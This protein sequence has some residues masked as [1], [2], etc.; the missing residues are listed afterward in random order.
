MRKIFEQQLSFD[1]IPIAEVKLPEGSRDELPPV[2]KALQYIYTQPSINTKIFNLLEEKVFS[3]NNKTGR[4]GMSLW[5]ILVLG[6]VRLCLDIDYDRLLMHAN[7]DRLTRSIL[8]VDAKFSN[9]KEYSLQS[10]KDNIHKIDDSTLE[11]INQIVVEAGYALNK[12]ET[13]AENDLA[14]KIDTYAMETN[15]HFPTDISLLWDSLR[16]SF[17]MIYKLLDDYTV[18]GWR[19]ISWWEKQAKNHFTDSSRKCFN[20]GYNTEKKQESVIDYLAIAKEI[21]IKVEDTLSVLSSDFLASRDLKGFDI[22][23]ELEYYKVFLDKQIDL[24]E[25]RIIKE[26]TIPASEKIHSI[27]E[28]YTEWLQKGKAGNKVELGLKVL[29]ATDQFNYIRHYQ[30]VEQQVDSDITVSVLQEL[31]RK[32]PLNTIKSFSMDKGFSSKK[33]KDEILNFYDGKLIMLKRGKL[34]ISE[35]EEENSKEFK[36][37]KNA[38]SAVESNINQLEH[39]GLNRCPDKGIDGF[40]RYVGFGVLAY[41]L[42]HLGKDLFQKELLEKQKTDRKQQRQ[43]LRA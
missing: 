24:V 6:T 37:L 13:E 12:T 36:K 42:H 2:L 3:E 34:N 30:V 33:N 20:K 1:I 26:E 16:K 29:I 17:D 9:P 40:K 4:P 7:Y 19:K 8:G 11:Q 43:K 41:N 18:D 25:R 14:I 10:L 39:N 28:P 35:K 22:L 23:C 31:I 21:S 15:V 27:F 38:H 5:E 32:Y